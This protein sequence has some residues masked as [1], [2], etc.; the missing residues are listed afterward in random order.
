MTFDPRFNGYNKVK[1][2]PIAV[3]AA[4]TVT[5]VAGIPAVAGGPGTGFQSAPAQIILVVGFV[6]TCSAANSTATFKTSTGS[7]ALTG[8]LELGADGEL[9]V[10]IAN[11]GYFQ[12]LPGDDLKLSAVTGNIEG[13]VNYVVVP[14]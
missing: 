7:A 10:P 2:A 14:A 4:A 12:T 8:T 1:S 5:I 6:L 3:A 9:Q 11:E 13:W